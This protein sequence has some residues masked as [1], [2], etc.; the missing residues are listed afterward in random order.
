VSGSE[1]RVT[2]KVMAVF[3]TRPEAIKMA[4]VIRALAEHPATEPVVA[5]TAQHRELL[6][7]VLDHFGIRPDYDLDIMRERQTLSHI[8]RR[9]L[10]GLDEVLAEARP[11]VVLVHGD[12]LTTFIGALIAFFHRL[13]VGHVEAGLRTFRKYEPFPEEMCRKLTAA[14]ADLHFAPTPAARRNL[15]AEGI[16]GAA[17]FVTGNTA[18]DALL[19]AVDRRRPFSD[20]RLEELVRSPGRLVIAEIHRRENWGEHVRQV[21]LAMRDLVRRHEDVRLLFSVHP[22]P[23]VEDVVR[24]VLTGEDRVYLMRPVEYPE[25][26]NLMDRAY[27]IISDSGGVQEEAPSLG[28][29]VLLARRVTERPEAVRAGTVRVVGTDRERVREAAELLLTSE[30]AYRAMATA[31]NPYGDGRAARRIVDALLFHFGITR[32]RPEEYAVQDIP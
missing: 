30:E 1:H 10:A 14:V 28:T 22:N 31:R 19:L 27:L 5:V 8:A 7:Q 9:A 29:P 17:I 26:A 3:G 16:D 20:P 6:D 13:P 11:D 12:T 4:P 18:I 15:E 2:L 25:W 21:C 24:E 32:G 23:V